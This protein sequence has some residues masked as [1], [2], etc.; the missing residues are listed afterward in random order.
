[1][2]IDLQ[3][4]L[5]STTTPAF[6]ILETYFFYENTSGEYII[7]ASAFINTDVA[8]GIVV[9]LDQTGAQKWLFVSDLQPNSGFMRSINEQNDG[10][11]FSGLS[12]NSA[13]FEWRNEAANSDYTAMFQKLD[14]NGNPVGESVLFNSPWFQSAG[15]GTVGNEAFTFFMRKKEG[16]N[17]SIVLIKFDEEGNIRN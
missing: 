10:Y 14:F 17:K 4:N 3:G 16:T 9:C 11:I 1:M 2:I 15:A 13:I 8:K 12:S 7:S 6:T 5:L